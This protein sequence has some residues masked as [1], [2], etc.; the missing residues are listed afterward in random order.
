MPTSVKPISDNQNL[1]KALQ[2]IIQKAKLTNSIAPL[3]ILWLFFASTVFGSEFKTPDIT[4]L[5]VGARQLGMGRA[6]VGVAD[7]ISALFI[8]PAGLTK[9]ERPQFTS[10]SGNLLGNFQYLSAS[11]AYP[12]KYGSF[13]LGYSGAF[14]HGAIT[15]KKINVTPTEERVIRDPLYSDM[16]FYENVF[17]LSYGKKIS[18][19]L[20]W[21]L[22]LKL[23]TGNLNGGPIT[24]GTSFGQDADI[25]FLFQNN[26]SIRYGLSL[27]NFLPDG[28]GQYKYATGQT[29]TFPLAV[30]FGWA[31]NLFGK[32]GLQKTP[33]ELIL[34]LDVEKETETAK[35]ANLNLGL[36]WA[37]IELIAIRLGLDQ[38][39]IENILTNNLTAGIGLTYNKFRFDYAY[40]QLEGA[41]DETHFFSLSYGIGKK[42]FEGPSLAIIIPQDK[43]INFSEILDTEVKVI[44]PV[45]T[46]L[47]IMDQT[48][49]VKDEKETIKTKVALPKLGKNSLW[50]AGYDENAK[51]VAAEQVRILNLLKFTDVQKDYWGHLEIA[52]VGTLDLISGYPDGTF[53]PRGNINRAEL[54]TLMFKA[55]QKQNPQFVPIKGAK[56]TYQDLSETHW[57][58]NYIMAA[59]QVGIVEGYPDKSFRPQQT[60]TRAEGLAMIARFGKVQKTIYTS[61]FEDVP[62]KHWA[63]NLIAGANKAGMIIGIDKNFEPNRNLIRSEA[64]TMVYRTTYV[65]ELTANLLNFEAG[66]ENT[67]QSAQSTTFDLKNK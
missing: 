53:R 62:Y 25:G 55:Y 3:L 26:K 37:P 7:D 6:F 9:I 56:T 1:I 38:T 15:T 5:S 44:N 47:K 67:Y 64:V 17:T 51:F 23:F 4:K 50:A 30:K 12:S 29:E 39:A 32:E 41:A 2:N 45:I 59:T 10:M 60:V 43:T 49:P 22:N 21:G 57:A 48:H 52:I 54:A 31:V 40:H 63:A 13:G 20:A 46:T 33:Q 11:G 18:E 14:A 16:N 27:K 19:I 42:K 65:K 35:P 58:K 34:A 66:Y 36:E 61:D 8:N 24:N 28:L